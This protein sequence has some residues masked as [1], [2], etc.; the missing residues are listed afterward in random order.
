MPRAW[1]YALS[2]KHLQASF[3]NQM[4]VNIPKEKAPRKEALCNTNQHQPLS[5]PKG[6]HRRFPRYPIACLPCPDSPGFRHSRSEISSHQESSINR[7]R[8]TS[9]VRLKNV[10]RRRFK[11]NIGLTTLPQPQLLKRTSCNHADKVGGHIDCHIDC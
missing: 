2:A 9:P 3:S 1:C 4:F 6:R 7:H 5:F 11:G 10:H 8:I